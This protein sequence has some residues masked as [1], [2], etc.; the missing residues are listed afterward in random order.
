MLGVTS[1]ASKNNI[2]QQTIPC[3]DNEVEEAWEEVEEQKSVVCWH[4]GSICA[5]AQ[6]KTKLT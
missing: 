3:K 5:A 6:L 4:G 1:L 2:A